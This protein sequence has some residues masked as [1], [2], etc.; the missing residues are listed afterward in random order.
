MLLMMNKFEWK[1]RVRQNFTL[2][3]TESESESES[4]SVSSESL[5]PHGLYGP[6]NSPDLAQTPQLIFTNLPN[7]RHQKLVLLYLNLALF[8][9]YT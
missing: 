3:E 9:F 6:L 1:F 8:P 7:V 4:R 2:T 5:Q